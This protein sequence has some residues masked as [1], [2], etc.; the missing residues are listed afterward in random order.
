MRTK[1]IDRV[2]I[3]GAKGFVGKNLRKFL[4]VNGISSIPIS[5]QNFKKNKFPSL[6]NSLHFVHLAGVGSES[7]NQDSFVQ[8]NIELTKTVIN[9]CKKNNIK[10][11]IYFSGL[12]V[13]KNSRSSYF[14]SKFNAEQLIKNSGLQYTIFRPSYILGNDDYLTKN[15]SK[16]LVKKQVLVPGSGKFLLQP[17]SIDDVC[18][19]INAALHSSKFSNKIIDLVG[20]KEITFQNLIK[21]SVSSKI[22]IKKINLELAY[23]KALNDINFEYG[24]EDL[25]ILVGNYVGNHKK[26][27][28]LCGF[29]F[30]KIESLNA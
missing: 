4:S 11:I 18:M 20:P 8:V 25:N 26:L 5:R 27:Q 22:K 21:N 7:V 17:I 15:I 10:N 6:K 1:I 28:N 19:C 30:Q 13:S 9:L 2:V 14:I 29:K 3:S 23:K 16:Q 24:V 12:G